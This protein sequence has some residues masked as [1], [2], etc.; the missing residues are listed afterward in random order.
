MTPPFG[1]I[2]LMGS[3]ELTESMVKT[4]RAILARCTPDLRA[5]FIDTPAGFELNCDEISARAVDYFQKR[6]DVPLA[7][8][9]FKNKNRATARE[10][11]AALHVLRRANFIFAGPGSPSYAIR[12]WR[13]SAVWDALV[14]R[15]R[16]GAHLIFASAATIGMGCCALPVYEIYKAGAEVEWIDGLDLLGPLGLKLAVVPHWNNA[17]G[18][19]HDTRYCFMGEPRLSILEEKLPFDVVILGIDEHTTIT[20]DPNERAITVMGVGNVMA[21][22]RGQEKVFATGASFSF[23][24]LRAASFAPAVGNSHADSAVPP[25]APAPQTVMIQLYLTQLARAMQETGEARVQRDLIDHAHDTMHELA[26]GW[27]P[28]DRLEG[29]DITPLVELLIQ[30]RM[31][32]RVAKQ[33]ALADQMRDQ[34]AG[35]GILLEDTPQGTQWKRTTEHTGAQTNAKIPIGT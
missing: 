13:G 30:I 19:T 14:A 21:R 2:T 20:L 18:G 15:W 32:L 31:Q 9:S 17:E 23:D 26:N 22:Y 34:L 12:H 3:G 1:T 25:T 4:H 5:V 27:R 6:L 10:V 16:Q 11:E 7:V 35:R 24:E 8:A 28:P 33:F 29:E